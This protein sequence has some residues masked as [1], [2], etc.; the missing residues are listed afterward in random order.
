MLCCTR[1]ADTN[2]QCDLGV[3]CCGDLLEVRLFNV[4]LCEKIVFIRLFNGAGLKVQIIYRRMKNDNVIM[5]SKG[6]GRIDR[7]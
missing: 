3:L 1:T 7:S 6:C 5:I 4:E 2:A